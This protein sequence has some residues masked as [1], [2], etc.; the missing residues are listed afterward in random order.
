MGSPS[1]S[2]SSL[3]HTG[4]VPFFRNKFPGL[5]Q[6]FSRTQMDF[7]GSKIHIDPYTPK[8][9]LII[10]LTALH[11]LHIFVLQDNLVFSTD[12]KEIL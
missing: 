2:F 1:C 12:H 7:K 6:D 11:T 4:F 10:L 3:L 9:S 8:I 5:F